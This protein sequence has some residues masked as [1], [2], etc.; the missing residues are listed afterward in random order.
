MPEAKAGFVTGPSWF[1]ANV[2]PESQ[3]ADFIR[4]K[5]ELSEYWNHVGICP[6][7]E[8]IDICAIL[9]G[10]SHEEVVAE[11]RYCG[12]WIGGE[13]LDPIFLTPRSGT[14]TMCREIAQELGQMLQAVKT[15]RPTKAELANL[16]ELDPFDRNS[17]LARLDSHREGI[18]YYKQ[19]RKAILQ[20]QGLER[21]SKKE[22]LF[23]VE[24]FYQGLLDSAA[25]HH[26]VFTLRICQAF[27]CEQAPKPVQDHIIRT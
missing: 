15:A 14:K 25:G 4:R 27:N 24:H 18:E 11:E 7:A 23:Y 12:T 6:H 1:K 21:A 22:V 10:K 20:M 17:I 9:I 16:V 26:E 3:E 13:R 8:L 2:H 5:T 19:F